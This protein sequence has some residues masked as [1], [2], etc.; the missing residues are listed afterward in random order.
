MFIQNRINE[1]EKDIC[2]ILAQLAHHIHPKIVE[3]IQSQNIK[4]LSY[5]KRLFANK[6][7][8]ENYLFDGSAGCD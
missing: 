1:F 6:I 2:S 5:F 3:R 8:L 7:E 4:E